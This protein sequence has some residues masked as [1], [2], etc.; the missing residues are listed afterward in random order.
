MV[1]PLYISMFRK[2]SHTCPMLF[3]DCSFYQD[4]HWIG[5]R[6]NLRGNQRLSITFQFNMGLSCTFPLQPIWLVVST[7]L[8]CMTVSWDDEIPKI[9]R[10]KNGRKPPISNLMRDASNKSIEIMNFP[11]KI[12][13]VPWFSYGF[14]IFFQAFPRIYNA[15]RSR[16]LGQLG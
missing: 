5:L 3:M 2:L 13:I 8:K 15:R 9:R 7:P 4:N 14:P 1:S 11:S 16:H 6:E 10:I 12:I